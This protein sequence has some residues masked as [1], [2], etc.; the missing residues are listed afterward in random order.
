MSQALNRSYDRAI[1]IQHLQI[2]SPQILHVKGVCENLGS[3]PWDKADKET[4]SSYSIRF[5]IFQAGF[6]F[7]LVSR[8]EDISVTTVLPNGLIQ[9]STHIPIP[10]VRN[11]DF[12]L[13]IDV[14]RVGART[15]TFCELGSTPAKLSFRVSAPHSRDYIASF[16]ELLVAKRPGQAFL[17]SGTVKNIGEKA[18]QSE[19]RFGKGT[20]LLGLKIYQSPNFD[21]AIFEERAHLESQLLKP[22]ESSDFLA[23]IP[24]EYV[25]K[26]MILKLN[27]LK[28]EEFWFDEQGGFA[29]LIDLTD[30]TIVSDIPQLKKRPPYGAEIWLSSCFISHGFI[31]SLSGKVKN[32]GIRN[33]N[34]P[35]LSKESIIVGVRIYRSDLNMALIKESRSSF[36]AG[37]IKSGDEVNFILSFLTLDLENGQYL[38]EV[39]L[40]SEHQFW[41]SQKGGEPLRLSIEISQEP[42]AQML[43]SSEHTER[44][45][46]MPKQAD[47]CSILIIAPTLP[48]FDSQAGGKRLYEILKILVENSFNVTYIYESLDNSSTDSKYLLAL[49][50]LGIE[51]HVDP[52]SFLSLVSNNHF[53]ACIL[54]WHDCAS[55]HLEL[56]RRVLPHTKVIVDSVD[57]EWIRESR[58]VKEELLELNDEKLARNKSAEL[59]TYKQADLAWVVTEDDRQAVQLEDSHIQAILVPLIYD[60]PTPVFKPR[61]GNSLVFIGGF[62]HPPNVSAAIEAAAICA[63][64]TKK[65]DRILKLFIIGGN[66]PKEVADLHDDLSVIVTGQ[67]DDLSPYLE[68]AR[69]MLAPLRY[70]AGL[71]GKICDAAYAGIPILTTSI[72]A[73]GLGFE[74]G[75]DFFLAETRTDFVQSLSEVFSENLDLVEMCRHAYNKTSQLIGKPIVAT[76]IISSLVYNPVVIAIVTYNK[77]ELLKKCLTSIIEKTKHPDYLIAILS[78]GCNDGTIEYLNQLQNEHPDLIRIFKNTENEFFVRPNNHI[79]NAFPDR[80]VVLINNDIEIVNDN[81][82]NYLYHAA[83]SSPQ[84]GAAGGLLL[85]P[86]GLV[87]EAGAMVHANGYCEN[88]GRGLSPNLTHLQTPRIVDYCSG[89]FLYLRR[90]AIREIGIFDDRFHPMYYEDVDWQMRLQQIGRATLYTPLAQA[91]H[92]EGSS[93][94]T[95]AAR[96]MKRFQEINRIKFVEKFSK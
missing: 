23:S 7:P 80:D 10:Y 1:S 87:S 21:E 18:W 68:E 54:A 83:Y 82:L 4:V 77:I 64:Y 29:H 78:N 91:V 69:A 15:S 31:V 48:Y 86:D 70:G 11:H 17:L 37:T 26:D 49:E 74:H 47:S 45:F 43:S 50:A 88:I 28:E 6:P 57:I 51:V 14:V 85:S 75:K 41:F 55:R 16:S 8:D 53:Q 40:L 12:T 25:A 72:G 59:D 94:G 3:T 56:I 92:F 27:V 61:T 66:P 89:C 35:E 76:S 20:F 71:K 9:F 84:I 62:S 46:V 5:S 19:Y 44:R 38:L 33:W 39:D 73:E 81:W 93:A 60:Y 95:E 65:S 36:K 58:G 22:G 96:G 24:H 63:D 32:T 42:T 30:S 34:T 67:V 13:E 2:I 79:M 90:D 52:I